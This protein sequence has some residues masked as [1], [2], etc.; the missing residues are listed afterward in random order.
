ME[1]SSERLSSISALVLNDVLQTC[2]KLHGTNNFNKAINEVI[3]DI[4]GICG[5][6]MCCILLVDHKKKTYSV[7]CEATAPN[8]KIKGLK[9]YISENYVDFFGIADT[10]PETIAGSTC[11]IIQ[12]ENDMEILRQR[13]PGWYESMQPLGINSLVLYPLIYNKDILGYL[14][15]VNL[16][17]RILQK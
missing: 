16:I 10:W 15:A 13:N 1:A 12:N 9:E 11:L 7:I 3:K 2:I 4:R 6:D 8:E 17:Q 14:W 5:A